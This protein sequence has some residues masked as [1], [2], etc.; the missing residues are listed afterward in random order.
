MLTAMN[1]G[2]RLV[3]HGHAN[4]TRDAARFE[5]MVGIGMPNMGAKSIR[6][7]SRVRWTWLC[8]KSA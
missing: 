2:R 1:T 7:P 5:T 4:N 8:S 6:E 3:G